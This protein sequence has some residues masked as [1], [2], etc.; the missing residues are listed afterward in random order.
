M[1]LQVQQLLTPRP[2]IR[3]SIAC[4]AYIIF[5]V[6]R[7][8]QRRLTESTGRRG[9]GKP[10][11]QGRPGGLTADTRPMSDMYGVWRPRRAE[12]VVRWILNWDEIFTGRCL[13]ALDH[14][15]RVAL[16]AW[17]DEVDCTPETVYSPA[18]GFILSACIWTWNCAGLE[19]RTCAPIALPIYPAT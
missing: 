11:T 14:R 12:V 3:L 19:N 7:R 1:P 6:W 10:G 18:S 8:G 5:N 2:L 13:P 15:D 4:R 9:R 16:L 17:F